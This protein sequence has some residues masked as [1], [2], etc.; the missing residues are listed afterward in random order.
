MTESVGSLARLS[1]I[2]R[3]I[4]RSR[5]QAEAIVMCSNGLNPVLASN[6]RLKVKH[7]SFNRRTSDSHWATDSFGKS[8]TTW[9]LR[10]SYPPS[11]GPSIFLDKS[12]SFKL[13]ASFRGHDFGHVVV[14]G[15]DGSHVLLVF[16][17]VVLS[18]KVGSE[19]RFLIAF[20]AMTSSLT[21]PAVANLPESASK[22]L[23]ARSESISARIP[24]RLGLAEE[25]K[26]IALK[27]SIKFLTLGTLLQLATITRLR[28]WLLQCT[29]YLALGSFA[30][31][32][33]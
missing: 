1:G 21:S 16:G 8:K 29:K 14:H 24:F 17:D 13:L 28:Q 5:L 19:H 9:L 33:A 31:I 30:V 26:G 20:K 6:K 32:L 15:R 2:M 7:P 18:L 12:G 22:S 27:V 23:P 3:F 11:G 25:K 10:C 4:R